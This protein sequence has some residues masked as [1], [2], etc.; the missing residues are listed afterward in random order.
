[1]NADDFIGV[2][3]ENGYVIER[4]RMSAARNPTGVAASPTVGETTSLEYS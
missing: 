4:K 2:G 3:L 1:M